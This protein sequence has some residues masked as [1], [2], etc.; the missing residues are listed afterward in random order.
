MNTDKRHR[1][2]LGAPPDM[3]SCAVWLYYRFNLSHRDVGDLLAKCGIRVR[4]VYRNSAR[5]A[6]AQSRPARQ[7]KGRRM[8]GPYNECSK[9]KWDKRYPNY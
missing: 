8:F 9:Y 6:R 2:E 5:S 3:T 7:V 4:K 1:F